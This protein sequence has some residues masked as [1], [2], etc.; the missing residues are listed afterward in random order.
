MSDSM[1]AVETIELIDLESA[2][3]LAALFNSDRGRPRL[4]LLLSPT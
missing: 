1:Q 2:E 3:E 4:V